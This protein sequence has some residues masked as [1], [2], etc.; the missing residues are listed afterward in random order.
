LING[1][2]FLPLI[3]MTSLVLVSGLVLPVLAADYNPGV[4]TG[5]YV[6]YGNFRGNGQGFEVFND[7]GF[8]Q[9][10]V[11]SVSGSQVTLLSTGQF[12]NGTALPGDGTTAV[13]DV[14]AGTQNGNPD[15]QGPIIAANLNQGDAIPPPSTYSVNSTEQRTYIG[16]NRAVNVL[17]VAVSSP[18]YNSS[19]TYIY[20]KASGMLLEASAQTTTQSEP[21]P[22]TSSYS[23]SVV[24]TNLFGAGSSATPVIDISTMPIVLIAVVIAVVVAAIAI[25]LVVALRKK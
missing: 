11:T 16:V 4:T 14:Q 15:T 10:Q 25:V 20:D 5:Q 17:E 18:D 21:S 22:I 13:W 9:L 7:Y 23:Y 1:K 8:L 6:K 19:L 12:K 24:E 2:I 3:F